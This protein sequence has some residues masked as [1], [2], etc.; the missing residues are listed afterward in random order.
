M[1]ILQVIENEFAKAESDMSSVIGYFT[2]RV[3]AALQQEVAVLK[4]DEVKFQ[5]DLKDALDKAKAAALAD[6]QA[7]D[8]AAVAS[9]SKY[10]SEIEQAVLA[11]IEA[12]LVP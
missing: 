10:V 6:V 7:A 5:G 8:P 4:A 11:V 3:K 2:G 1:S 9:V 12:H